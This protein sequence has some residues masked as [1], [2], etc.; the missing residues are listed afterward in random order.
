MAK[1]TPSLGLIDPYGEPGDGPGDF[2][3]WEGVT[4]M[5]DPD[6]SQFDVTGDEE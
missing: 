5:S 3:E 1:P 4:Y 2:D 6:C